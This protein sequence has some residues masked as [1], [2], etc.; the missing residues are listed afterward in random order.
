MNRHLAEHY[1]RGIYKAF[2]EMNC[3]KDPEIVQYVS[4]DLLDFAGIYLIHFCP[5]EENAF[6]NGWHHIKQ[7]PSNN[8]NYLPDGVNQNGN[9]ILSLAPLYVG[10]S[11]NLG[12]RFKQHLN[13]G[14]VIYDIYYNNDSN[15]I[16]NQPEKTDLC[17]MYAK[18]G[19]FAAGKTLESIFLNTFNF[20][21]NSAENLPLR[22]ELV[23]GD[24]TNYNDVQ[25][26]SYI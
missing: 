1:T 3:Q 22:N 11:N 9:G 12:D 20:A 18:L 13:P 25:V 10:F 23:L 24:P 16:I 2:L 15:E 21:R 19:H 14:G 17:F 26:A 8:Q 4:P 6:N 5:S 7:N